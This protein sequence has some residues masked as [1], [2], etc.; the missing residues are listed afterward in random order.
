MDLGQVEEVIKDTGGGIAEKKE[1]SSLNPPTNSTLALP[2][3]S[4]LIT[5]QSAPF[6]AFKIHSLGCHS[7][8]TG[9]PPPVIKDT[10]GGIA[11]KKEALIS[12]P[13]NQ[14]DSGIAL[15]VF[16]DHIPSISIPGLQNSLSVL[17][18]KTGDSVRDAIHFLYEKNVFGAPIT[19]VLE[20][21]DD[22]NAI[23]RRFSD[24]YVGFID[25]ASMVLWSLEVGELAKS[26]LWD[27]FFRI[28]LDDSLMHVLQL[29][30]THR[31]Q[32]LPVMEQPNSEVIGFVTQNAVIQLL[33]QSSGLE[34]FDNLADKAL[35][36][37]RFE[38]DHAIH[39]YGDQRIAEGF[40]VLWKNR[41]C[42]IAVL[43]REN[44]R[45]I[46]SLRS[47]DIHLLLDND[48]LFHSRNWVPSISFLSYEEKILKPDR[49]LM[50]LFC[51][52]DSNY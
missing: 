13:T 26:F 6:P 47:S 2:S 25:F 9:I 22:S 48:D 37:F 18:L 5:S 39:V 41:T 50:G 24:Q 29:L 7:F 36:E 28:T 32:I 34:W 17:E 21:S 3:K 16:L 31:L 1:A 4:F 14:L 19:D 38:R 40:H 15:Q 46:G 20:S 10:G 33:L 45:L 27:P 35:S 8:I 44:K 12:K 43:N 23:S 11:E 52:Q 49:V 30:S 42:P 51:Q